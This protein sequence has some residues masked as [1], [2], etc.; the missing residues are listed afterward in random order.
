METTRN[1]AMTA[2]Q[3]GPFLGPNFKKSEVK[4][5]QVQ[6]G[7][8]EIVDITPTWSGTLHMLVE[9]L[10]HDTT[11]NAAFGELL[12]MARIADAYVAL[13]KED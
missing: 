4:R 13:K 10:Q 7:N 3:A 12:R 11:Y 6:S 5:R 2:D 8:V 9:G 1:I